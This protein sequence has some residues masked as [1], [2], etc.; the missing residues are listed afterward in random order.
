MK[1]LSFSIDIE[2]EVGTD[3]LGSKITGYTV[4]RRERV[5]LEESDLEPAETEESLRI[6]KMA[7]AGSD[8]M[9]IARRVGVSHR[10]VRAVLKRDAVDRD[11]NWQSP[12]TVSRIIAS[13]VTEQEARRIKREQER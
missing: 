5:E 7:E 9:E 12:A 13:G 8:D 6:K 10:K 2:P 1:T 4:I 11:E 3:I